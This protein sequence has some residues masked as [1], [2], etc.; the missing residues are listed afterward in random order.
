MFLNIA[1]IHI[2]NMNLLCLVNSTQTC[3]Q[4]Y[5]SVFGGLGCTSTEAWSGYCP[6]PYPY[7]T[8]EPGDIFA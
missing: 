3:K 7:P 2:R 5:A 1:N 6:Y 4:E 8:V